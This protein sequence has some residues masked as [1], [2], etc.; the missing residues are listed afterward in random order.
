[1]TVCDTMDKL[2]ETEDGVTC[3]CGNPSLKLVCHMDGTDIYGY[4][5]RCDCGNSISV[6]CKR[7]E[8]SLMFFEE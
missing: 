6:A 4:Q 7:D 2:I 1:M 5:Y 8:E 3:G